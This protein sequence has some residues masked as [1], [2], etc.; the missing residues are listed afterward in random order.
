MVYFHTIASKSPSC[1]VFAPEEA[2]AKV[3]LYYITFR[4][5]ALLSSYSVI[6]IRNTF[7]IITEVA[8]IRVLIFSN[9]PLLFR[10]HA[11]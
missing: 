4:T 1:F 10:T 9:I 3:I 11:Y 7:Y 2:D 5:Y 8:G 6:T